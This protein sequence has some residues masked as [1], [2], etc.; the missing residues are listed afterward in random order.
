M[1]VGWGCSQGSPSTPY[2]YTGY[3]LENDFL[4]GDWSGPAM[5]PQ[6]DLKP[7]SEM[8]PGFRESC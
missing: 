8:E 5:D 4:L 6:I 7:W 3:R 2:G 1:T